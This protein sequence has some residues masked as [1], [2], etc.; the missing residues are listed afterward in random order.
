MSKG[1]QKI[2]TRQRKKKT[3]PPSPWINQGLGS[4]HTLKSRVMN[5]PFRA[6][7]PI[8]RMGVISVP[9]GTDICPHAPFAFTVKGTPSSTRRRARSEKAVLKVSFIFVSF[10]VEKTGLY[11]STE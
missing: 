3:T 6:I 1:F 9:A 11:N 7:F 2:Q 10:R 5:L 8:P 4:T